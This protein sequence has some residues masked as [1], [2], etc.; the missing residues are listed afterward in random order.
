[1]FRIKWRASLLS[2]ATRLSKRHPAVKPALVYLDTRAAIVQHA[3]AGILPKIIRP[4]VRNLTVAITANCNLRCVGCR[5]GPDFMLGQQL[6]WFH[7]EAA[8]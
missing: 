1:M 7:N 4:E 2:A 6:P 5:Y 8:A 3:A